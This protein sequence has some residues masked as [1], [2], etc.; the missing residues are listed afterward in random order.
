M[1]IVVKVRHYLKNKIYVIMPVDRCNNERDRR[2]MNLNHSSYSPYSS[3]ASSIKRMLPLLSSLGV[4]GIISSSF[5]SSLVSTRGSP[6]SRK[7]SMLNSSSLI[8]PRYEAGPFCSFCSISLIYWYLI[9]SG[10]RVIFRSFLNLV[11]GLS[12]SSKCAEDFLD[13]E[14]RLLRA[15]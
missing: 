9:D 8:S 1:L 7:S 6:S 15:L 12:F 14:A 5:S 3:P 4:S 2:T 11:M 13:R 10:F